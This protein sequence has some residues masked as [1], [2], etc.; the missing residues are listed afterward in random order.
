VGAEDGGVGTEQVLHHLAEKVRVGCVEK[1]RAEVTD[2]AAV[3]EWEEGI[4]RPALIVA[5]AEQKFRQLS[6]FQAVGPSSLLL[7][8]HPGVTGQVVVWVSVRVAV[9][10]TLAVPP[11][12]LVVEHTG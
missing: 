3:T 12:Y 5:V 8:P 11:L 2:W 9:A 7:H 10:A 1:V 4:S 6:L